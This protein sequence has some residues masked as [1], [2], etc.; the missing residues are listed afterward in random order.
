MSSAEVRASIDRKIEEI[1]RPRDP[2][3]PR[4]PAASVTIRLDWLAEQPNDTKKE[5]GR[6]AQPTRK[7]KNAF[8]FQWG[9]FARPEQLPTGDGDW[10]VWMVMA[11]RG[12]GKTRAGGG[13]GP[14]DR[15]EP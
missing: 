6:R 8:L 9:L 4:G 14:H 2:D 11:G 15:R 1:R 12:F 5:G 10:R 3:S 7:K 13:M